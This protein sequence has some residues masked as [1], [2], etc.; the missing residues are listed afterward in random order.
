MYVEPVL[1]AL[2][3]PLSGV[4]DVAVAAAGGGQGAPPPG[5]GHVGVVRVVV[6]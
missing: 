3:A 5:L 4:F 6:D 2:P 1:E